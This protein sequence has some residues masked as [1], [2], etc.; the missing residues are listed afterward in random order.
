MEGEIQPPDQDVPV[1]DQRE[2]T[3]ARI[4]LGRIH[5]E[6]ASPRVLAHS[7]PDVT[8]VGGQIL[9]GPVDVQATVQ[10]APVPD[11]GGIDEIVLEAGSL[12]TSW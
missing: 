12:L 5:V 3:V 2:I 10:E 1:D 9:E 11:P 4:P 8:L 7:D 6:L